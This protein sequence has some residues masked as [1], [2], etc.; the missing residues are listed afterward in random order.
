MHKR[1]L[2]PHPRIFVHRGKIT[3][4]KKSGRSRWLN[5][6]YLNFRMLKV[7]LS[8]TELPKM[9]RVWPSTKTKCDQCRKWVLIIYEQ[10]LHSVLTLI[11][12][13]HMQLHSHLVAH[14]SKPNGALNWPTKVARSVH[15]L[16]GPDA[17][18]NSEQNPFDV[19]YLK[20]NLHGRPLLA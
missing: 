6:V 10:V 20:L 8:V 16:Q 4:L 12:V 18:T 17:V 5:F 2:F 15:G 14:S 1:C 9:I 13:C 3:I 19:A 11:G 7:I